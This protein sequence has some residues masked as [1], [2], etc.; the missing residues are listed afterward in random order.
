VGV[1]A[2]I[3]S[4]FHQQQEAADDLSALAGSAIEEKTA[5]GADRILPLSVLTL[6][7]VTTIRHFLPGSRR[8]FERETMAARLDILRERV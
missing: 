3:Q 7:R 6:C 2:A 4:K 1:S 8:Q 5:S